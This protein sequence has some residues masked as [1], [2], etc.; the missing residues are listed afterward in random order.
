MKEIL[1][2]LTLCPLLSFAQK[3]VPRFENDTLYTTSGYKIYKG[4]VLH[5]A[6]GS[7][8]NG[9]FRFIRVISANGSPLLS[10]NSIVVEKLKDFSISS[11]G[12]AYIRIIGTITY[13]D[14][15]KGGMNIHMAFD[16]AIESFPGLSSELIVPDEFKNKPKGNVA[17]QISELYKLYQDSVLTKE[18]FDTEKKKLLDQ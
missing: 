9:S 16:K 14:G 7:R 18:E 5:F 10:N 12:N 2:I 11:L 15:S 8:K 13:R 1:F 17:D 3:N 4:A 6:R